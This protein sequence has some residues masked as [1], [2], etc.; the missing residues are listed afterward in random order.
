MS[1]CHVISLFESGMRYNKLVSYCF[2]SSVQGIEAVS[3]RPTEP[4]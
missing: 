4:C 2:L 1:S 3:L